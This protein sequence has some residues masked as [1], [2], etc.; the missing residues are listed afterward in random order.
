MTRPIVVTDSMRGRGRAYD[1]NVATITVAASDSTERSKRSADIVCEGV[2]DQEKIN[3]AYSILQRK[4]GSI[5]GVIYLTEGIYELSDKI[6]FQGMTPVSLHGA[7]W[8]SSWPITGFEPGGTIL[9]LSD[10][11]NTAMLDISKV[12]VSNGLAGGSIKGIWFE[13]NKANNMAPV[14]PV[15]IDIN[16]RGDINITECIIHNFKHETALRLNAHGC[17]LSNNDIED[18]SGVAIRLSNYRNFVYANHIARNA[19]DANMDVI[20]IER[21]LQ[22]IFGNDF[23]SGGMKF[24]EAQ[25]A[26][27]DVFIEN[28]RFSDFSLNGVTAAIALFD[29]CNDWIIR[30]NIFTATQA[31]SYGIY[32]ADDHS[33]LS[34][35]GNTFSGFTVP[36]RK[37]M[38][39]GTLTDCEINHNP[40]C[41]T[42]NGGV[43]TI[44]DGGVINHGLNY[45]PTYA[46]VTPTVSGEFASVTA[47]AAAQIQVAIKKHDGTPGTNQPVYWR[48]WKKV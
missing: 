28:N 44:N 8:L 9:K 48:A 47:M 7:T 36:D 42:E 43:N 37:I 15:A 39:S 40:G 31:G 27:N 46:E 33:R 10:G 32:S 45:T 22:W 25:N 19:Y 21:E 11:A 5:G 30:G 35:S 20:H 23:L 2:N 1:F 6:L 3:F 14:D 17:W 41:R 34:I 16:T 26:C 29:G 18:N 4:T 12:D 13:G 24:I 38:L